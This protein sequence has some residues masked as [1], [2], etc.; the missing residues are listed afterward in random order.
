MSETT[1][2]SALANK[3]FADIFKWLKWELCN[4]KDIDWD[5]CNQEKH[6]KRTHPSDL[7]F[8]YTNPYTGKVHYINTDLKSYKDVSINNN[9]MTTALKSLSMAMEC[10]PISQDWQNNYVYHDNYDVQGLLFIYNYDGS[11]KGNFYEKITKKIN[12]KNLNIPIS[13]FIAIF[14][15]D[16]IQYLLNICDDIKDEILEREKTKP[17]AYDFYYPNQFQNK[18]HSLDAYPATLEYIL[19][20]FMIINFKDKY[21]DEYIVY[22]KESGD[23]IEEFTYLI[24][25]LAVY[26]LI[27]DKNKVKVVLNHKSTNCI[28]NFE[29]AKRLYAEKFGLQS[30]EAMFKNISCKVLTLKHFY[31]DPKNE[32]ISNEQN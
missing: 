5:C 32:R 1:N 4:P 11:F 30:D 31:Y 22:Y 6:G 21:N 13:Q 7:V 29:K 2:T 23:S 25:T 16:V 10:A 3:V 20:P 8:Y 15:P 24:D 27:N 9:S 14:E 28:T 18:T 26:Q 19:S 17:D 12:I